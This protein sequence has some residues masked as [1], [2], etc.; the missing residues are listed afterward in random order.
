MTLCYDLVLFHSLVVAA[1]TIRGCPLM[2]RYRLLLH[3]TMSTTMKMMKP[4]LNPTE[5][6]TAT[7]PPSVKVENL[8]LSGKIKNEYYIVLIIQIAIGTAGPHHFCSALNTVNTPAYSKSSHFLSTW[9]ES[10]LLQFSNNYN[11]ERL[12]KVA[13]DDSIRYSYNFWLLLT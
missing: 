4:T 2:R 5:S 13:S 3:S 8:L 11:E 6:P 12:I 10:I 9:F 7:L 1:A